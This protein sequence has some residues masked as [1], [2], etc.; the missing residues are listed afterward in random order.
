MYDMAAARELGVEAEDGRCERPRDL[1]DPTCRDELVVECRWVT[2]RP[3]RRANDLGSDVSHAIDRLVEALGRSPRPA[4]VADYLGCS[5]DHVL[6]AL[7]A[8]GAS[9]S[10]RSRA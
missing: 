6:E 3:S 9:P 1:G 10:S 8:R 4:E 7:D 5:V 2:A